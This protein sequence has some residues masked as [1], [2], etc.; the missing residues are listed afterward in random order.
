M[1]VLRYVGRTNRD[2]A[3]RAALDEQPVRKVD[4]RH[5]VGNVTL[6]FRING[7]PLALPMT[8]VVRDAV[9]LATIVYIA[10]ELV[11]RSVT[12][13]GW[14]RVIDAVV[15]VRNSSLWQTAGP[16]L[17]GALRFL[18]GD[19]FRF[20][21]TRTRSVPALR[22]HRATIPAGF[23]TVCLFSGGAD[24]LVGAHELLECGKKV[25]LVGHQADGIT[26][27]TQDRVFDF[28]ARRF[29]ENVAFVQA[30]V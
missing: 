21:W 16:R 8:T 22:K 17:E 7:R 9:D 19:R 4:V 14:S 11:S 13:D 3:Y 26:A 5:A 18:S 15:P 20:Q 6:D 24:S 30:R 29:R 25:L 27:S 1:K 12:A 28:L 23:D 2:P 10:D